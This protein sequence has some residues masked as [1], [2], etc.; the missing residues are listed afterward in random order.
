M[1][2]SPGSAAPGRWR[3]RPA[4]DAIGQ[5]FGGLHSVLSDA[6]AAQL[7][8]TCL[9]DLITGLT[10]ATGVLA[11]L[12]GRAATGAGQHVET[13]IM[14]AVESDDHRCADPVL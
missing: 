6:G 5:A 2:R 4:Y 11:A 10:A 9:A 3:S 12:V 1:S 13:S 8:G 14:E 7:S